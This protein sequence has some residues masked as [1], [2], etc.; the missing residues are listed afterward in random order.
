MGR[1]R[2]N[3]TTHRPLFNQGPEQ[4]VLGS[5]L[6]RSLAWHPNGPAY[7]LVFWFAPKWPGGQA[8]P[9]DGVDYLQ[10]CHRG[11]WPPLDLVFRLVATSVGPSSHW[12]EK[13][14]GRLRGQPLP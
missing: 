10:V 7:G 12:I 14:V 6:C 11:Q 13:T 8:R 4:T 5:T 2:K 9:V 3:A 1:G